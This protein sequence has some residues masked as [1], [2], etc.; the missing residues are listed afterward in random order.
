MFYFSFLLVFIHIVA[1]EWKVSG[2]MMTPRILL[3][4]YVWKLI[5][6]LKH[7]F[8]SVIVVCRVFR[9]IVLVVCQE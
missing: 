6:K 1:M 9:S 3:K 5:I 4:I 7:D 2:R 8:C